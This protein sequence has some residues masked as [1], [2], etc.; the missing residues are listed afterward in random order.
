MELAIKETIVVNRIQKLSKAEGVKCMKSI[1]ILVFMVILILSACNSSKLSFSEKENVPDNVQDN[2][3]F[4]IQSIT[5]GG[6]DYYFV[7]YSCG[8][9][10]SD[11]EIQGDKGIQLL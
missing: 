6:K 2:S 3:T 9:V 7:F 1:F 5:D 4:K 11:L 10:E 8:D